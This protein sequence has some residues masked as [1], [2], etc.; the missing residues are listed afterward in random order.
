MPAEIGIACSDETTLL[1][2][3]VKAKITVPR[4]MTITEVKL[5]L[6][7]ADTTGLAIS[8][9]DRAADPTSTG[10]SMLD[11]DLNSGTDYTA[12]ATS[13]DSAASSY[14]HDEDDF[15]SVEIT[16]IGDGAAKGLKVWLLGY[17]T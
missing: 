6:N 10:T 15:V 7:V 11:E 14:S 17:W 3:G 2:T 9:E 5:S 16:D 13:F 1:T 4:A 8:L 12:T